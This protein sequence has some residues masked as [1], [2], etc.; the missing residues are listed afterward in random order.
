M[1]S[2]VIDLEHLRF[3]AC[4][5]NFGSDTVSYEVVTMEMEAEVLT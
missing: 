5:L 2:R 4:S 1:E 3:H